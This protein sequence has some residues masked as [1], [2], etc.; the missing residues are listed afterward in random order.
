MLPRLL[1]LLCL[2]FLSQVSFTQ[3]SGTAKPA[4]APET[5]PVTKPSDH[6]LFYLHLLI[7]P[8]H[9]WA[10]FGLV[11]TGL[12]RSK[13]SGSHASAQH[14]ANRPVFIDRCGAV[15]H[16]ELIPSGFANNHRPEGNSPQVLGVGCGAMPNFPLS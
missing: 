7:L 8:S 12:V 10:A 2:L 11:P 9:V 14:T 5:C 3:E 6:P 15:R 4:R 13:T 1:P 16:A